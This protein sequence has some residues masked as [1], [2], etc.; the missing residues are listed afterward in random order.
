MQGQTLNCVDCGAALV[1][2]PGTE[3]A[4]PCCASCV[5][6]RSRAEQAEQLAAYYDRAAENF[7]VL[8]RTRPGDTF[9][10]LVDLAFALTPIDGAPIDQWSDPSGD[11][12]AAL[13][14]RIRVGQLR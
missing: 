8:G 4:E 7:I 2:E 9:T 13:L 14:S 10:E 6:A 3:P 1:Y 11:D 5:S 12:T